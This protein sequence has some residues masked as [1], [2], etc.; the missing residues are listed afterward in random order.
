MILL[1]YGN[2]TKAER[3][4]LT[5]NALPVAPL[6]WVYNADIKGC[7]SLRLDSAAL[8]DLEPCIDIAATASIAEIENKIQL[9]SLRGKAKGLAINKLRLIVDASRNIKAISHAKDLLKI[10]G[11]PEENPDSM[12]DEIEMEEELGIN[13]SDVR[14]YLTRLAKDPSIH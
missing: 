4:W 2:L 7:I 6:A 12:P 1:L 11:V 14:E 10:L 8:E 9:N 5:N 3:E 13:L